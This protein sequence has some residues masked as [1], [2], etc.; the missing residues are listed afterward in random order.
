MDVGPGQGPG[1]PTA[2][3]AWRVAQVIVESGVLPEG[4]FQFLCGSA[5]DLLD[6]ILFSSGSVAF[7]PGASRTSKPNARRACLIAS[8]SLRRRGS[9][10][11]NK[12]AAF[13]HATSAR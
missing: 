9:V 11:T 2:M 4:A 3:V 12:V 8:R 5:G 13:L 7:F 6:P 1:I 10:D